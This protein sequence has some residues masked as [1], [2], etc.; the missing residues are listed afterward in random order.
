LDTRPQHTSYTFGS[1]SSYGTLYFK[2]YNEQQTEANT[3]KMISS[4]VSTAV[5]VV[6]SM[7]VVA[8]LVA[9]RFSSSKVR[10]RRKDTYGLNI[11]D[12]DLRQRLVS[13]KPSRVLLV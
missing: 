13:V 12:W 4:N 9:T 5:K 3:T 7:V 8:A 1:G 6:V 10:E 2:F 11:T